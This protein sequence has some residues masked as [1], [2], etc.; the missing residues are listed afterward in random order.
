MKAATF[1]LRPTTPGATIAY[2]DLRA[3]VM[4]L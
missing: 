1:V 3:R 4:E 2:S